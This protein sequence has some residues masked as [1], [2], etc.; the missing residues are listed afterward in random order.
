MNA[1]IALL[2]ASQALPFFAIRQLIPHLAYK[3]SIFYF[4]TTQPFTPYEM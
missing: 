3:K 1:K 4:E 2:R